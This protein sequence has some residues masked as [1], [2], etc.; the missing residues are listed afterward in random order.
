MVRDDGRNWKEFRTEPNSFGTRLSRGGVSFSVGRDH[1]DRDRCDQPPCS[2][3]RPTPLH[4]RPSFSLPSSFLL[5]SP[6]PFLLSPLERERESRGTAPPPRLLPRLPLS[7]PRIA[8]SFQMLIA[9]FLRQQS[10]QSDP[11]E[12]LETDLSPPCEFPNVSFRF[13]PEK[14]LRAFAWIGLESPITGRG[15]VSR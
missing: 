12:F 7:P 4:R 6:T 15:E 10:L 9:A 3:Q 1:R 5:P 11:I 2:M 13:S 8:K 14:M